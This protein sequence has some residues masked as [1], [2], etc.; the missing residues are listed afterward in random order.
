M[1]A[2]KFKEVKPIDLKNLFL[3]HCARMIGRTAKI[4]NFYNTN[5]IGV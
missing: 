3:L 4:L 5:P 1:G 2:I